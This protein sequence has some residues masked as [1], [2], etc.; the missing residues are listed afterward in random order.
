M[1]SIAVLVP[2]YNEAVTI[3]KV[4]LDFKAILPEADIYIYD[5]N[6]TDDTV[7][8]ALEAGAIVRH[9][10]RQGKGNVI[11]TMFAQIDADIYVVVDGDDTY[12]AESAREMIDL[13]SKGAADMVIGDRLSGGA[14]ARE[15]KRSFHNFGNNL[16]KKLINRLFN[17]N[18]SDIMTG[19]RALNRKFVKNF[20]VMS[21]GFE[22]ET[23]MT[24]HALDRNF[25]IRE[26][27]IEYRDRPEGSYSKLSTVS[28]GIRVI[29]TIIN[30]LKDYR[31][32]KFFGAI[33]L[34]FFLMGCLSGAPVIYQYIT[35]VIITR[36]PFAI[37]A[38]GLMIMSMLSL[39]CALILDMIAKA[40]KRSYELRLIDYE[41]RE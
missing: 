3:K 29:K 15:N 13:V 35:Q 12:P 22:L 9:E 18:V 6:S 40:N 32:L 28:D 39:A 19:Y 8:L 7:S 17:G 4:V 2:C 14:Y 36:I 20:A 41:K 33:S 27:H 31:P 38:V 25:L 34:F 24:I 5:N 1:M 30:I 37:L 10:P 21:R 11:R 26:V 16:V 23:E